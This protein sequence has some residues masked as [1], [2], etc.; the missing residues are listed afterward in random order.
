MK[1]TAIITASIILFVVLIGVNYLLWDNSLK[2]DDIQS[3]ETQKETSQQ[4][5]ESLYSD[6]RDSFEENQALKT[7]IFDLE[8]TI[9]DKDDEIA[10]LEV[11]KS[12]VYNLV[13]DKNTMIQQFQKHIDTTFFRGIVEQWI[14]NIN[15]K[16]YFDAYASHDY[17]DIFNGRVN[18]QHTVYALKFTNIEFVELN[19]FKVRTFKT[20]QGIDEEAKNRITFD[21]IMNVE[22]IKDEDGFP[23]HDEMFASGINHFTVSM[24]FDRESWTWKIWEIN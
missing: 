12:D 17:V 2:K 9:R 13:G 3:L 11:E 10:R 5:F 16:A 18:I 22:L 15:D 8:N 6:Y 4:S 1:K 14:A 20:E 23:V 7:Q 21:M 19:D 24:Y